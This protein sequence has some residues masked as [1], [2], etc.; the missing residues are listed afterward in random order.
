MKEKIKRHFK[1]KRIFTPISST[2]YR[3]YEGNVLIFEYL[4]IYLFGFLFIKWRLR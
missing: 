2:F 4:Y 1:L 3:K